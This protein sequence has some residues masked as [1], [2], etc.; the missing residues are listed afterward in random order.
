MCEWESSWMSTAAPCS[1]HDS[2][3][4]LWIFC[5]NKISQKFHKNFSRNLL[6]NKNS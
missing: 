5:L 2:V 3:D 4:V 6:Y 1:V